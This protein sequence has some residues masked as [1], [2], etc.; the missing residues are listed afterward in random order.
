MIDKEGNYHGT[1]CII[2]SFVS[3]GDDAGKDVL[4]AVNCAV[5]SMSIITTYT[6]RVLYCTVEP[7]PS[8]SKSQA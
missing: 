2:L 3:D 1:A 8:I 4:A 6:V 7:K 5:V